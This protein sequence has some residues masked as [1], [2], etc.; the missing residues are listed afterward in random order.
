MLSEKQ[1]GIA[2]SGGGYRAAIYHLGT[3]KK[4]HS[5][6]VLPVV[7][8]LSTISGGSIT[9]AAYCLH[10]GDFNTF[11]KKMFDSLTTKSV[12]WYV[13]SSWKFI[14]LVLFIVLFLGISAFLQFTH[15]APMSIPIIITFFY[16][17]IKY[18]FKIFPV[19]EI[20]EKAYDEFFYSGAVLSQ[21]CD[22]PELAIGSTNLQTQ[23]HFTFSKRKMEDSK[24]AYQDPPVFF[25][26]K[27][28]PVARAV[29]ASSCVPFAFT[30]IVID[31]KFFKNPEQFETV[32]PRL[33][34]GGV[35]DNQGA[36]K[37][38][39][40]NSSYRCDIVI[41][42]DAGN[43]LPFK[44]VYNNTFTLLLRTVDLFMVRIKHF[45]MIQN[46]YSISD[47]VVSF[48]SIGWDLESCIP[49][50]YENWLKGN[51][52]EDLCRYH[53][54]D[55]LWIETPKLYKTEIIEHLEKKCNFEYLT[56]NKL[57]NEQ[58]RGIRKIE[59]NLKP[60]DKVLAKNLMIHAECL[61]ELQIRLYCPQIIQNHAVRN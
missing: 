55:D 48:Q 6:G 36:H 22:K 42:S 44:K 9:G 4:L 30:P 59:T 57:S 18:Q 29:I 46:L 40:K 12:I 7:D 16:I 53:G 61:T 13:L 31:Q 21:F 5:L 24:Y 33:V 17:I 56:A 51:I 52:S 39:Q 37:L 20:I 50:F 3:F 32:E 45:Q 26:G 58:V 60:I 54:F 2:L 41:V 23:R 15:Y 47:I 11:E 19:S 49:G 27:E 35:Y 10:Q 43:N 8:K 1:I 28:F 34:D 25:E 38:T 14:R